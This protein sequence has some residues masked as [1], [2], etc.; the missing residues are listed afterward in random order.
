LLPIQIA[1]Y[2]TLE[3]INAMGVFS[4]AF[5]VRF[6]ISYYFEFQTRVF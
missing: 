2:D 1:H 6:Q 3:A 4:V 5:F